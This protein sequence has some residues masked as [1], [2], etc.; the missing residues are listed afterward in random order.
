[1][2]E[3]SGYLLLLGSAF[4]SATVLPGSSEAVMIGLLASAKGQPGMLIFVAT[5]GN[6]A[7][8]LVNYGLG[9]FAQRFKD[10]PWF[11]ISDATNARA[12]RWFAKYGVWSLLLS[13]VPIVGDPLTL[14]A[15]A[16]RI[17]LLPFFLL[18]TTGKL[19]RYGLVV[20]AWAW[21]GWV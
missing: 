2:T 16:M 1:M 14:I 12:Q 11:P 21:W 3:L 5:V 13:W 15:G 7:G 18:V 9:Y 4:L 8:S 10:R 20:A 19:L 17:R 6:V